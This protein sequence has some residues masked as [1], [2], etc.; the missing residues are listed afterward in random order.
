MYKNPDPGAQ[1]D[2]AL[3]AAIANE[4][5]E[6]EYNRVVERT[7]ANKSWSP[8][9]IELRRAAIEEVV[10]LFNVKLVEQKQTERLGAYRYQAQDKLYPELK[11]DL[12]NWYPA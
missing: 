3:I 12:K 7:Y 6:Q 11:E 8:I 4:Y 2:G 9:S 5:F 1:K 10:R